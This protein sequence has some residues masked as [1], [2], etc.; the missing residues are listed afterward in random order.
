LILATLT[1]VIVDHIRLPTRCQSGHSPKGFG[2]TPVRCPI[3][4]CRQGQLALWIRC[5][6]VG[7]EEHDCL[8][9]VSNHRWWDCTKRLSTLDD[10]TLRSSFRT[11]RQLDLDNVVFYRVNDQVPD[12]VQAELSHNVAAV[13]FSSFRAQVQ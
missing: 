11:D 13:R 8:G 1:T 4:T 7:T 6:E 10:R 9:S 3:Q 12:R 2:E 5:N